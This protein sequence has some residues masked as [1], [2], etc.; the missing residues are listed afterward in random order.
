MTRNEDGSG[1]KAAFDAVEPAGDIDKVNPAP[2][3]R[4][5]GTMPCPCTTFE[6]DEDCPV[7]YPSLLCHACD[8]KGMAPIDKVVAFAAEM[9]KIAEQVDEL[10]DP[11]A[12]WETIDLIKSQH[13]QLQ[14]AL[15]PFARIAEIEEKTPAG[16]ST[17]VN[18]DRCREARE[19]L[20]ATTE[21]QD[22]G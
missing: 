10:E 1:M 13:G 5:V 7:G 11:F 3:T 6:Q 9:M 17:L 18:I 4:L 22:N 19:I 2:S 21:G 8:G 12:A 14:A 16:D 15:K 20:A